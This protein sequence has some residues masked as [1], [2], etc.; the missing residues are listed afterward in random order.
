MQ[1]LLPVKSK[2]VKIRTRYFTYFVLMKGGKVGMKKRVGKDIW[3]G[4]YDFYLVE[5][6]R[7]QRPEVLLKNDDALARHD[8]SS[9]SITQARISIL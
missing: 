6:K 5:G 7:Q 2:K 3:G 8:R 9:V 1:N 4:L